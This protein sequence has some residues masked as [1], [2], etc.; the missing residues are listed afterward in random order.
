MTHA[1][2]KGKYKAKFDINDLAKKGDIVTV[3]AITDAMITFNKENGKTY[4]MDKKTFFSK[5]T[6]HAAR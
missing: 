6:P 3:T 4:S 1:D 5:F 2:M